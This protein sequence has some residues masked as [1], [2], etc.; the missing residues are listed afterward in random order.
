MLSMSSDEEEYSEIATPDLI[1][2]DDKKLVND[3]YGSISLCKFQNF[4]EKL[5]FCFCGNRENGRQCSSTESLVVFDPGV[6]DLD[7]YYFP[8]NLIKK[9][10]NRRVFKLV[11]IGYRSLSTSGKNVFNQHLEKSPKLID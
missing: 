3:K 9:P 6:Q 10:I 4:R 1:N 7:S 11:L 2:Y 5:N 8:N